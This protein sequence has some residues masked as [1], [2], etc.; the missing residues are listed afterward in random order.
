MLFT[1]NDVPILHC[2]LYRDG[3]QRYHPSSTYLPNSQEQ[4][5]NCW[6]GN[7]FDG[8]WASSQ[9]LMRISAK[10]A[11][12]SRHSN[13]PLRWFDNNNG[14]HNIATRPRGVQCVVS[15]LHG[16]QVDFRSKQRKQPEHCMD[17]VL[18]TCTGTYYH[19]NGLQNGQ[20]AGLQNQE[21]GA[22]WRS[23]H[24]QLTGLLWPTRAPAWLPLKALSCVPLACRFKVGIIWEKPSP[25]GPAGGEH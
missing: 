13:S 6:K 2:R 22:P 9:G 16:R 23:D 20:P 10:E 17:G 19:R 21:Q 14:N 3:L 25:H 8:I 7:N 18:R 4:E 15:M 11:R 24:P 5:S 12:W 1:T